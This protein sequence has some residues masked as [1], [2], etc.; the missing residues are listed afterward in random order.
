M[1]NTVGKR[2]TRGKQIGQAVCSR[3]EAYQERI[4]RRNDGEIIGRSQILADAVNFINDSD[5]RGVMTAKVIGETNARLPDRGIFVVEPSL[6]KGS[7]DAGE[8]ELADTFG[9]DIGLPGSDRE[10]RIGVASVAKRVVGCADK[11][12][13]QAKVESERLADPIIIL[14]EPG[15]AGN[16]VVVVAEAAA[17]LTQKRG[18]RQKRLEVSGESS[19]A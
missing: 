14:R 19:G 4:G 16:A 11:F 18:T 7:R 2:G 12:V 5:R 13:S 17:A 8:T 1:W 10:C 15:I 6:I 9:I 3:E